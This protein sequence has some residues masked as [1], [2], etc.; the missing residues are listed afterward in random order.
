MDHMDDD[1]DDGDGEGEERIGSDEEQEPIPD[2]PDDFDESDENIN[3]LWN[4]LTAEEKHEFKSMLADG[5]IS[6]LLNDYKPWKPWWL[7]KTQA[8]ALITDLENAAA[9]SSSPTLPDT[10]PTIESNIVPLPTL[11]S[12]LPH[13]HVRFDV[14]EILFAYVLINVRYRGDFNSYVY[15]SGMEFLHIASRHFTQKSEVFD[16]E[17]DPLSILHTRISLLREHLQD[18]NISF[19]ISEEFFVNSLADTLSIIH[20]PYQNQSSSN[21][22]VLS[23]LSDLKR[24]LLKIQQYK[25]SEEVKADTE[26]TK[27]TTTT[28]INVFHSNRTSKPKLTVN[29]PVI[30]LIT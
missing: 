29:K 9:S 13:I 6:H 10:I 5:R 2:L 22:Y 21:L 20:G 17:H 30:F 14:F 16:E 18:E 4:Y 15:E 7:H 28:P 8:P 24:F 27:E 1:E 23:A 19:R 12:I 3:R 11:T 26:S 25:P